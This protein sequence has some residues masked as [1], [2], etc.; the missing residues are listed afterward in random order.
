M[1]PERPT[2]RQLTKNVTS[3]GAKLVQTFCFRFDF[4]VDFFLV[5]WQFFDV[6]DP[7]VAVPAPCTRDFIRVTRSQCIRCICRLSVGKTLLQTGQVARAAGASSIVASCSLTVGGVRT[8]SWSGGD[9]ARCAGV[10]AAETTQSRP[11]SFY[12]KQ[13]STVPPA[14]HKYMM[15][16]NHERDTSVQL[17][18]PKDEN[19]V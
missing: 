13:K 8:G 10:E 7:Q 6:A 4:E 16:I 18:Q 15:I 11:G 19:S 14:V 12:I 9:A 5:P 3:I 1:Y 17:N 2:Q